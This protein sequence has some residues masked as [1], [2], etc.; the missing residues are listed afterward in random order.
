MAITKLDREIQLLVEGKNDQDIF[1]A[2]IEHLGLA[3]NIQI[4]VLNGKDNLSGSLE[5]LRGTTG[6]GDVKDIAIVR[7]ADESA[8]RTFQ[9]VQTSLKH[10]GLP[11]PEHPEEHA[12]G[13]PSVSVLILP[14]DGD[15]GM[16]ETLL[17]RTFAHS[18]VNSCIDQF[19]RCVKESDT[20]LA[21]HLHKDKARVFAYLAT[22][23]NP[24]G[25]YRVA[26]QRRDWNLD[27]AAFD[28]VRRYLRS[29]VQN[30]PHS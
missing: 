6:Y 22:R 21:R 25:S 9:S 8:A 11:V 15:D 14:G 3:E 24:H 18:K 29:L 1:A 26:T 2:L 27:H 16:L 7:D 5:I 28:G 30:Q 10:A 20:T 12:Q 17:C 4:H 13:Q 19:F 23:H